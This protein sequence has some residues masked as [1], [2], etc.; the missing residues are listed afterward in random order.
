MPFVYILEDSDTGK[1]YTGSCLLL[2]KRVE[3]HKK[4]TGGQTTSKGV[5]ELLCFREFSTMKEARTVEKL[6]KSQKGGNGFKKVIEEWS[7]ENLKKA[8]E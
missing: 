8:V 1:H 2:S 3:R 4:H 5:W 7:K 6:V